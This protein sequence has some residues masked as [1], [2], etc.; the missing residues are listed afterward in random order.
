VNKWFEVNKN[1]LAKILYGRSKSYVVNELAQNAW[2]Q[3]VSRVDITLEPVTTGRM[4]SSW[5]TNL[6]SRTESEGRYEA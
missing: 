4:D 2:D 6:F 5:C 1:G 3:N